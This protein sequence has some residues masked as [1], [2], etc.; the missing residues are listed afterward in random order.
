MSDPFVGEIRMVAFT[1]APNGW[2]LCQGQTV[3]ISQ[4]QALFA[5]LGTTYGG[6][7]VQTFNLP[8]LAGRSP[9]GTGTGLNLTPVELGQVDG[10]ENFTLTNA[11]LPAHTHAATTSAA[12]LTA[13]V[14]IP[15]TT[16][17]TGSVVAP[18][19]NTVLGPAAASGHPATLYNTSTA[20]TNLAP[21]NVNVSAPAAPVA[22][23][24]T[25]SGLPLPLRNPYLGMNFA[26]ALVGVF[27]S[28]G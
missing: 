8:N 23:S 12:T 9:V 3:P 1:F 13:S 2:A 7:G 25:G 16:T 27:P 24:M 11:Q 14:S 18:A 15:A 22:V 6:D 28:R 21:F 4:N 5:L 26:I 19:A 20:N 10:L 17:A